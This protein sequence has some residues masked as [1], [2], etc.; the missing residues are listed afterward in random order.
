LLCY[1]LLDYDDSYTIQAVGI[2]AA[3][4]AHLVCWSLGELLRELANDLPRLRVG[5]QQAVEATGG[6]QNPD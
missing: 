2:Y 4:Y 3:R 1:V 5:F 6:L